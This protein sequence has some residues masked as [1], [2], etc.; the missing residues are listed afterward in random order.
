MAGW[1][2]IGIKYLIFTFSMCDDT[3][4]IDNVTFYSFPSN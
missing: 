3:L 1:L 2:L 4:N